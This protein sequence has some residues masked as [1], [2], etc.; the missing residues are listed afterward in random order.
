MCEHKY[1]NCEIDQYFLCSSIVRHMGE[2][3]AGCCQ[4]VINCCWEDRKALTHGV[5]ATDVVI[6][7]TYDKCHARHD[8]VIKWKHLPRYWPF[9]W[10]IH[11]SSVNSPHK[12]QWRGALMFSLICVWI[13]GSV[14]NRDAGDF[15]RHCAHYGVN[16]MQITVMNRTQYTLD[17]N[18]TVLAEPSPLLW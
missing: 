14:N 12:G 11:R 1:W 6:K 17:K 15:R 10:G 16:V 13:I 7:Q 18:R 5:D 9:V 3:S 2:L 4:M 8:D